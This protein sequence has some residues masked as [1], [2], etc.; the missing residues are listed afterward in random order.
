MSAAE[1]I[2][3]EALELP[4]SEREELATRLMDSLA[5]EPLEGAIHLDD[6]DEIFRRADEARSGVPGIPW[7]EVKRDLLAKVL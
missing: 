4:E 6:E 7:E 3:E 2:F 1:R 5:G